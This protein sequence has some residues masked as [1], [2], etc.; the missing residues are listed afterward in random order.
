[1]KIVFKNWHNNV[2]KNQNTNL[3]WKN[4]SPYFKEWELKIQIWM[5]NI[6]K[7]VINLENLHKNT[8]NLNKS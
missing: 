6:S 3:K 7:K 8:S 2:T 4:S 1:M 5:E